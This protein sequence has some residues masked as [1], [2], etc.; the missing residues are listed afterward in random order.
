VSAGIEPRLAPLAT[1]YVLI[2]VVTGPMLARVTDTRWF[3]RRVRSRLVTSLA[4]ATQAPAGAPD[5]VPVQAH[6]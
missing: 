1:A 4:P 3:K 2:T 5:S 6:E